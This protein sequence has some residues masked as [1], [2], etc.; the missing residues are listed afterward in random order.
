MISPDLYKRNTPNLSHRGS[1]IILGQEDAG[2]E[3][4]GFTGSNHTAEAERLLYLPGCIYTE[5]LKSHGG[6]C[7]PDWEGAKLANRQW[8]SCQVS[9]PTDGKLERQQGPEET[10]GMLDDCGIQCLLV[11]TNNLVCKS[12]K[13]LKREKTI[14]KPLKNRVE[15]GIR[16]YLAP[17]T[18]NIYQG[19]RKI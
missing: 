1:S 9:E 4:H 5:T 11:L 6:S 13:Q 7:Q 2:L 12:S 10:M 17:P 14:L 8:T 15:R 16:N 18:P 19:K 3:L